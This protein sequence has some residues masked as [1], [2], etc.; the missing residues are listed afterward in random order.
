[1][2]V[3]T[4]AKLRGNISE[5]EIAE[6]VSKELNCRTDFDISTSKYP[7][8]DCVKEYYTDD[9][10]HYLTKSGFIHLK[11]G[12][13][14]TRSLFYCKSNV[15]FYENLEYYSELGLEEMVKSETTHISLGHNEEAESIIYAIV[16]HFGGWYCS[17]DCDGEYVEVKPNTVKSEDNTV[18]RIDIM[19]DIETL[20][21]GESPPVFQIAASAFDIKTGDIIDN[22]NLVA[23]ITKNNNIEGDTLV[24]WLN[25]NKE[26]LTDLLNQGKKSE[27]DE[28]GIVEGF[29]HWI[30]QLVSKYNLGSK[31]VYLWGNGILFDN[32]IIWH[33]CKEYGIEYPIFYRNDRDMRTIL[34]LAAMKTGTDDM[35]YKN[36]IPNIGTAHDAFDD[37][38]YQINVVCKCYKDLM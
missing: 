8:L 1:M 31:D 35:T 25:T 11:F 23:D 4:I 24:W 12:N 28:K 9:R 16:E 29:C 22:I 36:N 38:H 5:K 27:L 30:T 17:H 7:M 32:R 33:K 37:V 18:D 10:E 3:D 15:N 6:F 34:E 26:L 13:D 21:R 14:H 19:V 20:G 2:G